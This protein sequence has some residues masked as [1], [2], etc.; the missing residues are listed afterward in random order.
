MLFQL[1]LKLRRTCLKRQVCMHHACITA[2]SVTILRSRRRH[3]S[4][5]A[6]RAARDRG[7]SADSHAEP[8]RA[9]PLRAV[10]AETRCRAVRSYGPR[11]HVPHRR[12]RGR[13][14]Y[15]LVSRREPKKSI[16]APRGAFGRSGAMFT[17]GRIR[18]PMPSDTP[19]PFP[20]TVRGR[21]DHRS[22]SAVPVLTVGAGGSKRVEV[23]CKTLVPKLLINW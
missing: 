17:G 10:P 8:A 19:A 5:T 12:R 20:H 3:R 9:A 14:R 18:D 7:P 1:R 22:A 2:G 13:H 11:P 21:P 4:E 16:F 15:P 23:H 6:E